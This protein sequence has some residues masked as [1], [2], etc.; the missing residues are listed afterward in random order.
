MQEVLRRRFRRARPRAETPAPEN[1]DPSLNGHVEAGEAEEP[2]AI[3]PDLVLIDGGKGPL[4]ASLLVLREMDLHHI[5][6]ASLAKREEEVFVPDV[7]ESILLPRSSPALYM[8][9]RIR[10]EAHRFA[11]TYHQRL[12]TKRGMG[13][14]MDL[15]PGI[16]PKRKRMLLRHFGT[17]QKVREASL[18][19]LA[20]V[21]GMTHKLAQKV[22]EYL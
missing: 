3:E 8:L 13:S 18:D 9:Q 6:V 21:P 14:A 11:I 20:A 5:P 17:V 22:K 1:P 16:G 7:S 12:R 15:V 2:W 19:E 4:N 10:D